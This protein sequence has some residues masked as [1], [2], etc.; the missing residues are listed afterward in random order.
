VDDP[1]PD[2]AVDVGIA[3]SPLPGQ[4]SIGDKGFV[5]PG[6]D[7]VLIGVI[8]GLGHGSEAAHAADL[9]V[10][11]VKERPGA[12]LQTLI[13]ECHVALRKTRGVVMTLVSLDVR[14]NSLSW[15]GVGN[16]EAL[17]MPVLE[18]GRQQVP[19]LPGGVVGHQLPRVK[20]SHHAIAPGDLIV[21][22]TDGIDRGFAEWVNESASPQQIADALL[23]G[24]R[25]GN[26]DALV[27]VVRY[28][29]GQ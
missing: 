16:V 28:L 5:L 24:C 13:Q 9:A 10:Q 4:T 2:P 20:L 17:L 8:D 11:A 22:V 21:L 14:S 29:G 19:V 18:D 25:K 3:S 1:E 26:D 27:L 23:K 12:S 7:R 15:L 6:G